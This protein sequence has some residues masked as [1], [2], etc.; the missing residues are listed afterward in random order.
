MKP[1]FWHR[2]DKFARDLTPFA[3]TFI[4]L[5]INAIPFHIPGFAQVAPLLPLIGI[6]FW[7]VY[8][9]DLMPAAAV[10]LIGILHDFLAGLPVGISALIFLMVLGAALAQRSFF[11]GKSFVIV[12]IGFIFVAAGALTLEWLLL[13]VVS[14]ELIQART[15][16]YQFGL[17]VAFFPVLARMFTRWQQAFLQVE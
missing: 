7:A 12:W 10:F 5:V 16:L 4:L 11:F 2:I 9:P 17:T 13:S 15:A 14:S 6:Y 3:L 1:S 8:R